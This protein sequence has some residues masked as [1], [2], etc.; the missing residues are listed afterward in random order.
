MEAN[1]VALETVSA[2]CSDVVGQSQVNDLAMNGRNFGAVMRIV[3][4]V[5]N[6]VSTANGQVIFER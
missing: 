3:P 6:D 1:A 2:T 5:E 4:G